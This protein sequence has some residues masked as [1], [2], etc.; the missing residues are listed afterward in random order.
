M[1]IA[2]SFYKREYKPILDMYSDN[3]FKSIRPKFAGDNL[4]K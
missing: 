2:Y 1:N 3:G 4:P